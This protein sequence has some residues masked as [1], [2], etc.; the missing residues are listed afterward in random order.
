M[1]PLAK[2]C[3]GVPDAIFIYAVPRRHLHNLAGESLLV[4]RK[5]DK[6]NNQM[7]LESFENARQTIIRIS[8]TTLNVNHTEFKK[9]F[10]AG[11]PI[12]LSG[13]PIQRGLNRWRKY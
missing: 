9:I 3:S 8:I 6:L 7:P 12:I 4:K 5:W 11:P 2:L 1:A 10:W 13:L